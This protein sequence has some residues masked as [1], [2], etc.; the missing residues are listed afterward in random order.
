MQKAGSSVDRGGSCME[1]LQQVAW[2]LETRG[3]FPS[4][5][6][7]ENRKASLDATEAHRWETHMPLPGFWPSSSSLSGK[8]KLAFS[9]SVLLSKHPTHQELGKWILFHQV[10]QMPEYVIG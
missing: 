2:A 8:R 10:V 4:P 5:A 3:I 9:P 7:T 1:V 6:G